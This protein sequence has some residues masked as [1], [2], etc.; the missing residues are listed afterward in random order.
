MHLS[1][2]RHSI[3][4]NL[5]S[6]S[7]SMGYMYLWPKRC[8]VERNRLLKFRSYG[9]KECTYC[10][11]HDCYQ[12]DRRGQLASCLKALLVVQFVSCLGHTVFCW[13]TTGL[14]ADLLLL[15]EGTQR[16]VCTVEENLCSFFAF[17]QLPHMALV[18]TWNPSP[19]DSFTCTSTMIHRLSLMADGQPIFKAIRFTQIYFV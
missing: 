16:K 5:A 6:C 11:C 10:Y 8:S 12:A 17:K 14:S 9:H 19:L 15:Y 3:K 18:L 1:R 2:E 7:T 13:R 4:Q